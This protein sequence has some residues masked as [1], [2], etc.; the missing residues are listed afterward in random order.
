MD[1]FAAQVQAG[2]S[3]TRAAAPRSRGRFV[4]CIECDSGQEHRHFTLGTSVGTGELQLEAKRFG[5][6]SSLLGQRLGAGKRA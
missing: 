4:P 5:G 3:Q 6:D 2:R 1:R